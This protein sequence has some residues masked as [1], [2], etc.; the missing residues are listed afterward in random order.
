M[1]FNVGWEER[2]YEL[3]CL[4]TQKWDKQEFLHTHLEIFFFFKLDIELFTQ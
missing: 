1:I 3:I 2:P 4:L